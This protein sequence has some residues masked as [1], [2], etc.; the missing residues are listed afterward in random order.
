MLHDATTQLAGHG[1]LRVGIGGARWS[2]AT[3]LDEAE[4][5]GILESALE[6]GITYIDTARAYTTRDEDAHNESIIARALRALGR[7][8]DVLVATKGGHY[9]DGDTWRNDGRPDSLRADCA[10][11]R[12]ALGV[13]SLDLYYLHFPDTEVPIEESIGA[14]AELR[15]SGEIKAIG[16]SN[17]TADQFERAR[18]VTR[19]DAVQNPFSPYRGDRAVLDASVAA[20]IPFV[21]YSPLGGTRR[22]VPLDDVSPTA[23]EIARTQGATVETVMLAWVLSNAPGL[24]A[25]TGA[26]R[27]SSLASSV[28]AAQLELSAESV[29]GI[30][31]DLDRTVD[32]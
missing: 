17:V 8:D 2:I 4:V 5:T 16:I 23:N 15:D 14:L 22:S 27:P 30:R 10:A 29:A 7:A 3:P 12:R 24:V 11:S 19:I 20:G 9:R 1:V 31:A 6:E 21:A 32:R 26:S 28:R 18:S 13:D 25:I